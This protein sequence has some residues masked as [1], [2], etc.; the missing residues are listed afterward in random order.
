[1]NSVG[2]GQA[3]TIVKYPIARELSYTTKL[4]T[5]EAHVTAVLNCNVFL[6][7][8]SDSQQQK[9]N[10]LISKAELENDYLNRCPGSDVD[11]QKLTLKAQAYPTQY[12]ANIHIYICIYI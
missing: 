4:T 3:A 5:S 7:F 1:M 2:A 8:T 12:I 10:L 9:Q 6:F 11:C